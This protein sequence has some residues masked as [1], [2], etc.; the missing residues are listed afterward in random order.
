MFRISTAVPLQHRFE[1][2]A[3]QRGVRDHIDAQDVELVVKV[4]VAE[5]VLDQQAGI[6]HQQIDGNPCIIQLV[7]NGLR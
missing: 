1:E 7:K 6:V 3:G 2:E 5:L 4:R